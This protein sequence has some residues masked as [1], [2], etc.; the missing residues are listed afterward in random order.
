ESEM[1]IGAIRRCLKGEA[2]ISERMTHKLVHQVR[3]GASVAATAEPAPTVLSP[4][5]Q[6][7]VGY[8][9]QGASN[10]EIARELGVAESTVKIHV[11][12]ILRKLNLSSRVQVA[13]YASERGYASRSV[14]D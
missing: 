5:E 1:L 12:H 7:I 2:A 13:V 3:T 9:A 10:K 4:R 6:E 11:Q 8:I 14:T